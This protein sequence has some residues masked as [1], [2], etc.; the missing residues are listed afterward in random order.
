MNRE[1]FKLQDIVIALVRP[2]TED[3]MRS[4]V[5]FHGFKNYYIWSLNLDAHSARQ[6]HADHLFCR[7]R[8]EIE[9][10]KR[11]LEDEKANYSKSARGT[12]EMTLNNIQTGLPG[13]FQALSSFSSVCASSFEEI[14]NQTKS[15]K[16]H[17]SV[18][19]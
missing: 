6:I 13:L 5:A 16:G 8:A 2:C 4:S 10:Y 11:R 18:K 12:R 7:K 19:C 17:S 1:V 9:I 14:Y 3:M 15:L